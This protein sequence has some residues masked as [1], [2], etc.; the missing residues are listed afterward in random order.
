M[1]FVCSVL[2]PFSLALKCSELNP[3]YLQTIRSLRQMCLGPISTR[4]AVSCDLSAMQ[5]LSCQCSL[6]LSS[7]IWFP[8]T[9][10]QRNCKLKGN[11][12]GF[13]WVCGLNSWM[14]KSFSVCTSIMWY[15]IVTFD[16]AFILRWRFGTLLKF[17]YLSSYRGTNPLFNSTQIKCENS[18]SWYGN[19][20][21]H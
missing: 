13:I 3:S 2:K 8:E 12:F 17:A 18:Y 11:S 15:F 5:L 14:G 4:S 21:Q 1:S 16:L 10:L 19:I 20:P 9:E 7:C 6:S